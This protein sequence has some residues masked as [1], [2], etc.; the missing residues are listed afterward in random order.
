MSM[1]EIRVNI[2]IRGR[3]SSRGTYSINNNIY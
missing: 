3:Y 2:K 1:L